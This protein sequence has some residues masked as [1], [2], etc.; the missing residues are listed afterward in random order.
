MQLS[1]EDSQE[2]LLLENTMKEMYAKFEHEIDKCVEESKSME[3]QG[4]SW[5]SF[6][7]LARLFDRADPDILSPREWHDYRLS[8]EIALKRIS[9]KM[10]EPYV[11]MCTCVCEECT[12][13][14]NIKGK[15]KGKGKKSKKKN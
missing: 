6:V 2:I 13:A 7:S 10:N 12:N 1:E 5:N 9:T 4:D 11:W 14:K 3:Y 15:G 8:T